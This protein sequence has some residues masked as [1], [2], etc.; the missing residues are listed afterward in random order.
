M[1]VERYC[2]NILNEELKGLYS[3]SQ[4]GPHGAVEDPEPQGC[5]TVLELFIIYRKSKPSPQGI[6][7][8]DNGFSSPA[9]LGLETV[10]SGVKVDLLCLLYVA[11]SSVRY[12]HLPTALNSNIGTCDS[13]RRGVEGVSELKREN[14]TTFSGVKLRYH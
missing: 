11:A 2:C 3:T 1:R 4:Y 7:V 8:T 14:K 13:N 9:R 12:D 5:K 10:S 6:N